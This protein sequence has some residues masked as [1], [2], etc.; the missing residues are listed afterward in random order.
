MV[1]RVWWGISCRLVGFEPLTTECMLTGSST[2]L[3]APK[4]LKGFMGKLTAKM[5]DTTVSVEKI[6][7]NLS[8][9][10]ALTSVWWQRAGTDHSTPGWSYW[11]KV[12]ISPSQDKIYR[13]YEINGEIFR[14]YGTS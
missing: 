4:A 1:R 12:K 2:S 3:I 6:P 8:M 9:T 7:I 5:S 13:R 10:K 14:R 11:R